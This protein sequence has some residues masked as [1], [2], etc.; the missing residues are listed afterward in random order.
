MT[1]TS[2]DCCAVTDASTE[3][4]PMLL[5][6]SLRDM[7]ILRGRRVLDCNME[8]CGEE[9]VERALHLSILIKGGT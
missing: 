5:S 4:D 1:T 9:Y 6:V 3:L 2:A 8:T 7:L